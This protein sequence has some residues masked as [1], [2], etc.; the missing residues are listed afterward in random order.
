METKNWD[1]TR[2]LH[3]YTSPLGQRCRNFPEGDLDF[4]NPSL[5][6]CAVKPQGQWDCNVGI[7]GISLFSFCLYF[8]VNTFFVPLCSS[9]S[10]C[11]L[12]FEPSFRSSPLAGELRRGILTLRGLGSTPS[13]PPA[14]SGT[15]MGAKEGITVR[16]PWDFPWW[17]SFQVSHFVFDF[18]A[19]CLCKEGFCH[20]NLYTD[21]VAQLR[22][23]AASEQICLY[24]NLIRHLPGAQFC[25]WCCQGYRRFMRH[26]L[27]L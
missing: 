18:V 2:A 22:K 15:S 24:M 11:F 20:L 16:K 17:I 7:L 3:G 25:G 19:L 27:W 8:F 9:W 1:K 26:S 6:L 10:S 21:T 12:N 13:L 23:K 4:L 5:S 14:P